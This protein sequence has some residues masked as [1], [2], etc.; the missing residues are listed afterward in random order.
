M[1]K[2]YVEIRSQSAKGSW[3][4]Q[5]P[6]TYVAVQIVP[7]GQTPLTVLNSR[8]AEKRGIEIIQC[9][10]G[11]RDRQATSRSMLRQAIAKAEAIVEETNESTSQR[12]RRETKELFKLET[13]DE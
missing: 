3:P 9:G 8:V 1:M 4:R 10:E 7:K 6:D 11:Y 2:A 13:S 12:V 5:G